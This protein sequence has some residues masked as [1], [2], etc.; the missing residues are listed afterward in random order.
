M[1]RIRRTRYKWDMSRPETRARL[2]ALYDCKPEE[3]VT[4]RV[5]TT[6]QVTPELMEKLGG[7]HSMQELFNWMQ[8][9]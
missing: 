2:A 7:K 1:K 6:L 9:L 8:G 4:R 5:F 3:L